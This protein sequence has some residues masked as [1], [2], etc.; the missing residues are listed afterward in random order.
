VKICLLLL[1]ALMLAA[2]D[3][4][5]YR[6]HSTAVVTVAGAHAVTGAAVDAA[7]DSALDAVEAEHPE[8][9]EARTA[10]LRAEAARWTP[11][12][13][14]LDSIRSALGT[15][16][17]AVELARA[18]DDGGALLDAL[19]PLAARVLGLWDDL[20]ALLQG[21]DVDAPRLPEA[22]RALVGGVL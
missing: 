12:G 6:V 21:L 1:V 22:V 3:P 19:L 10:A 13:L 2:C 9:G 7:R 15:W 16:L 18:A 4:S 8:T 17:S 5:A 14:A 20:A 11:A